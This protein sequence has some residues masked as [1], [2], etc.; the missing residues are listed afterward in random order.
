MSDR[1]ESDAAKRSGTAYGAVRWGLGLLLLA[2]AGLKTHQLATQPTL[3]TSFLASRSFLIFWIQVEIILGLWLCSGLALRLGYVAAIACFT[4]FSIVTF[5]KAVRGDTTCG[6]FGVIEVNPWYTLILDLSALASAIVF[7]PNL[8]TAATIPQPRLRLAVTGALVMAIGIP[9]G[10][11]AAMYRP[12]SLTEEGEII[13]DARFVVLEP[14][15]WAGKRFPL[16]SYV[17]VSDRLASGR[18]SVVLYHHDCPHCQEKVPEFQRRAR[19]ES[20]RSGASSMAMIELP[21]YAPA[22]ESLVSP[23]SGCLT[24]RVSDVR[25]WFVETPVILTL[26]NGIVVAAQ[27]GEGTP[28]Q[29]QSSAPPPIPLATETKAPSGEVHSQ[30]MPA[31]GTPASPTKKD[32]APAAPAPEQAAVASTT[33]PTPLAVKDPPI[34]ARN[35]EY[36]FGFV[37]P[38]SI[39]KVWL[40]LPNPS[41]KPLVIRSVRSECKC[42]TAV[43]PDRPVLPGQPLVVQVVLEAPD[44]PIGYNQRLLFQTDNPKCTNLT[45]RIKADVG[46]PLEVVPSPLALEKAASGGKSEGL[47]IIH[48]RGKVPIRLV[49]ST[50]AMAGCFAQLPQQPVPAEGTLNVPIVVTAGGAGTRT[51]IV[52]IHTDVDFQPTLDVPIRLGSEAKTNRAAG[53]V[54]A[55]DPA[56]VLRSEIQPAEQKRL[57]Q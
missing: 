40:A 8:R 20:L 34:E 30:A 23:D 53:K 44:K 56:S 7:R 12:A 55:A 46:R 39:H 50:S 41:D 36:H 16:L 47:V 29:Q 49:Y 25:D 21:P 2:A 33:S 3:D 32:V 24:G 6:C 14:E 1:G 42:M 31:G 22:G 26:D 5:W 11:A 17:D 43:A 10:L 19:Q 27:A 13:G 9:A 37:D 52:Q 35:G 48:N 45:L 38:K 54:A 28:V 57:T 15:T 51:I 18:W 4:L